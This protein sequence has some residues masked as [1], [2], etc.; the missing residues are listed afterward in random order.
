MATWSIK[1]VLQ[2][3]IPILVHLE[4]NSASAQRLN[5]SASSAAHV[6]TTWTNNEFSVITVNGSNW[7]FRPVLLKNIRGLDY[8]AACGFISYHT[9]ETSSDDRFI[10][11]TAFLTMFQGGDGRWIGSRV[12]NVIWSP[13]R[14]KPLH[15][16][17][18]LQ[19][20]PDGN[21][22]L[23]D[24]DGTFLWST[25]T[26][27]N[28]I[29]S[30]EIMKNGN[31]ILQDRD[32]RTIWQSF[33]HPTDTL[34]PGQK[35]TAGQKLVAKVSETNLS[36]GD[37]YLTV[38]Q[39]G[40][41]AFHMSNNSP[42]KYFNFLVRGEREVIEQSYVKAIN[43]TLA[44]YISSA[45]PNLPD[46][47]FSVPSPVDYMRFDYDGHLRVY[48]GGNEPVDILNGML[49]ECDYP[50]VCGN[51]E[52][53]S[54]GRCFC[55]AGFKRAN[56]S[57][58]NECVEINPT[59]CEGSHSH[60]FQE[61]KEVYYFEYVGLE[62]EAVNETDVESCKQACLRDCSCKVALFRFFSDLSKG[63]CLLPSPAL[64]LISNDNGEYYNYNS[65]AF[66]KLSNDMLNETKSAAS[67][68]Q[69]RIIVGSVVAAVAVTTAIIGIWIVIR[70]KRTM[71]EDFDEN[72][73][74]LSELPQ[75]FSYQELKVATEDFT[76][77][78]GAG[79]F[80]S[81]YEGA[82]GS[83]EK[84]AVKC[85]DY[86]G[87]GKKEFLAE[88]K[89]IGSIHHINLVKLIGFCIHKQFKL[90]VYEFMSNGSLDRWIYGKSSDQPTLDWQM[91]RKIIHDI[92][93][94]LAYLHEE[95]RQ[96][97]IH[98]DIKPQNIL[99]DAHLC[100]K[101]SDFGLSKLIDRDESRV[102]TTIRGTPGYM[103]PE[104]LSSCI[105][106]KADVYSFG[107]VVMEI[108]C[109]RK[110][111]DR[112]ESGELVH[113]LTVFM[114][115]AEEDRLI[116]M[117]DNCY[118]GMQQNVPEI[119]QMMRLALWCLQSDF[120]VRPSMSRVVQVIE[121]T[122]DIEVTLEHN[123]PHLN[124][125]AAITRKYDFDT[126]SLVCPSKLSGPR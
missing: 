109:G 16:N 37:Y 69:I 10:F 7:I 120:I 106:E 67:A 33:D 108:V 90:L 125:L 79:G 126:T 3:L 98:L 45:E 40:V 38:N 124:N 88:V 66:I 101:I 47:V 70:K 110:N 30:M 82:L 6:S 20:L 84:I 117:I 97:I 15:Q 121:G 29:V 1:H 50:T 25:N 102:M 83:G 107:I 71:D 18:T 52:L 4:I 113:L 72:I 19:F 74:Q 56:G 95:C 41:F 2:L 59:R 53:C 31:L 58:N 111:L 32:N 63:Y 68:R 77:K 100:A 42:K 12:D 46:A 22:I 23:K 51:L 34:L 65:S 105:T 81:V 92:A 116:D 94:G 55:P 122:S 75:R 36:E 60:G 17:G 115:K 61:L 103:A 76:R 24:A 57:G 49:S 104:W 27:N 123:V 8:Y 39:Q 26:S 5:F 11:G 48:S 62:D 87:R 54:N 13:S 28:S 96:T 114:K 43:G 9:N 21:L 119:L 44:L 64:S 80:G 91:R 93:K 78:I 118:N 99:L 86:L 14:N 89:T 85:L 35:L 112:N 73:D